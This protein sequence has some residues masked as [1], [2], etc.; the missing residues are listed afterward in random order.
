MGILKKYNE[1]LS[2]QSEG[3]I[4]PEETMMDDD[5]NIGSDKQSELQPL[6]DGEKMSVTIDGYEI[7]LPSEMDGKVFLIVKDKK[8]VKRESPQEV[9]DIISGK[10]V[11]ESKR[12]R[13]HR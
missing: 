12:H 8:H 6:I 11:F 3:E 9:L 10:A 7:S 2:T 5:S 4:S 1:Y 13:R